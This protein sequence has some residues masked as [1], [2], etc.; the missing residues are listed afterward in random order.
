MFKEGRRYVRSTRNFR[1]ENFAN[2][3]FTP[4]L[5]FAIFAAAELFFLEVDLIAAIDSIKFLVLRTYRRPSLDIW[6]EVC[7]YV[8]FK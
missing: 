5:F 7:Q 2:F 6:L 8:L 4:N 1:S 3:F